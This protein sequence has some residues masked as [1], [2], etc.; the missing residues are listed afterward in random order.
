[1]ASDIE[2]FINKRRQLRK[3]HFET[4]GYYKWSDMIDE[5]NYQLRSESCFI[6]SIIAGEHKK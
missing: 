2:K 3:K 1:M 6:R 5:T 4:E